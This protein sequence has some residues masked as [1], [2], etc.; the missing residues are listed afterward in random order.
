MSWFGQMLDDAFATEYKTEYIDRSDLEA[1]ADCPH[2]G[3]LRKQHE[4]EC[5][6]YDPLPVVGDIVHKIAAHAI[7]F[8]D[9]NL[10]EAADMITQ[11]LPKALGRTDLQPDVIRAGKHLAHE[12]LR[13]RVNQVLLSEEQITRSIMPATIDTGEVLVTTK[14]DLVLATNKLGTIL[15]LDYKSGWLQRTNAEA[16]DAFQTCVICWC[17]FGKY[18]DIQT[19][20]FWYLETRRWTRAYAKITRDEEDNLQAR[21]FEA[22]ALYRNG[23]DDAWP[24]EAKCAICPVCKWCKFAVEICSELNGDPKAFVDNTIVLDEVLKRRHEAI[25]AATKDGRVLYGSKGYFDDRPKKKQRRVSFKPTKE[26]GKD[27]V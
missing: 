25:S 1:V 23:T 17:L 24:S 13:F 11:E 2:Q 3:Q 10:Q 21:I 19:I 16:K 22:I 26:N 6:T 8:C 9:Y 18:P 20:H 12:L 7:K 15:N 5:E 4:G 14:P 27:D